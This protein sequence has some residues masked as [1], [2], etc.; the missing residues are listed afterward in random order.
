MIDQYLVIRISP[1][2]QA[3]KLSIICG[4]VSL[5]T[6]QLS[7]GLEKCNYVFTKCQLGLLAENRRQKWRAKLSC[8][9]TSCKQLKCREI[10]DDADFRIPVGKYSLLFNCNKM[11]YCGI[12]LYYP[13]DRPQQTKSLYSCFIMNKSTQQVLCGNK[14]ADIWNCLEALREGDIL[15]LYVI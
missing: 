1:L 3:A 6:G 11:F 4:G 7:M 14:M 5:R 15:K 12:V 2:I 10:Q 8:S 13:C 9:A